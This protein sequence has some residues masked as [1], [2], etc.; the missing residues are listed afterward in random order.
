[1][2]SVVKWVFFFRVA[3]DAAKVSFCKL[4]GLDLIVNEIDWPTPPIACPFLL[5]LV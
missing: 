1:M 3:L 5:K 2:V 4:F